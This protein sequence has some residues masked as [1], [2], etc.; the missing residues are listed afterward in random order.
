MARSEGKSQIPAESWNERTAAP[1]VY[2]PSVIG[3]WGEAALLAVAWLRMGDERAA[4][5]EHDE[6]SLPG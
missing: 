6:P 5:V 4:A 1:T 3:S 2:A